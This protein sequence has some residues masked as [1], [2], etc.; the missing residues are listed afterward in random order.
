MQSACSRGFK[1]SEKANL[2]SNLT[3]KC[4]EE[5]TDLGTLGVKKKVKFIP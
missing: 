3:T 4:S 2:H 5:A 1:G